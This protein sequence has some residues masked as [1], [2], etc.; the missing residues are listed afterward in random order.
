MA[1]RKTNAALSTALAVTLAF[2]MTPAA[3][4]EEPAA[5][6][7][8][9]AGAAVAQDEATAPDAAQ[10]EAGADAATEGQESAAAAREVDELVEGASL[11]AGSVEVEAGATG[12]SAEARAANVEATLA[13]T[14]ASGLVT[15]L[16]DE[17]KYFTRYE[18]SCNYDQGFSWGDGYHAVGYYQFDNRYSLQPFLQY[19]YR[20]NPERYAMFAFAADPSVDIASAEMYD[21]NAGALTPLGQQIEN[22]W[23]AAYLANPQEF[24]ALQDTY[25]YDNY[26][27]VAERYLQSRGVDISGRADC[28]RGLCWGVCNLFGSGGWVRFVGGTFN[29]VYY[30]GCGLS[31]DMSD[32][33]FATSLTQYIV[34]H[35]AEFY[36]SQPQYH[37]GWQNRY[38]NEQ[39]DCLRYLPDLVDGAWYTEAVDYVKANGL[40][41]GY[42][43]NA[44]AGR[45]GPEDRITRGQIA[46]VLYRYFAGSG[47][48]WQYVGKGYFSDV[49]AG[50]W[51]EAA[52]NWAYEAGIVSGYGSTGTFGPDD[53]ATREQVATIM[54]RAA[55][56]VGVNVGQHSGAVWSLPDAGSLSSF[57]TD[58]VAWCYDQ[59]IMTGSVDEY[60]T[61]W[62]DPQGPCRRAQFA[63]MVMV[64][65][66][67]VF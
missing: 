31:D 30:E 20:F 39:A 15:G 8:A 51:Y 33:E 41:S 60:G 5:A 57:A 2:G 53:Y 56:Y 27:M 34:D 24:A 49:P 7:E 13:S 12:L 29:G 22:A 58:G 38:R 19:C 42:T 64:L 14:R 9:A 25:A 54:A 47:M 21:Y 50:T 23:H 16:S 59:G 36:P 62:L 44:L 63:K 10:S 65:T 40:M 67:D 11:E 52:V 32:V 48:D 37:E 26:Y 28:V 17:F 66:R 46:A 6:E 4:A 55:A 1:M 35:V 61:A 43:G 45:F 3:Q 18:S